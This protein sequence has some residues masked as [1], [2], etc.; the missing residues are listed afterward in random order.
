[1]SNAY[2]NKLETKYYKESIEKNQVLLHLKKSIKL[3][4]NMKIALSDSI[5]TTELALKERD[6][7]KDKFYCCICYDK[8]KNVVI[9]PCSHFVSCKECSNHLINCPICRS[10]IDSRL[11][12][13]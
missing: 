7:I 3:N 8:L 9:E 10:K 11:I 12:L 6:D 13:F 2:I 5:K 4:E 1:M